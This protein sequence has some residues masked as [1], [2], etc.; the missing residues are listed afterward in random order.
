MLTP[1]QKYS[2]ATKLS[3]T[4]GSID[5]VRRA[6]VDK[7]FQREAVEFAEA[8]RPLFRRFDGYLPDRVVE[9]CK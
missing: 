2:I 8:I 4:G 1:G 6:C 3:I 7:Q 9:A 5:R